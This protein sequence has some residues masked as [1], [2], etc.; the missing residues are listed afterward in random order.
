MKKKILINEETVKTMESLS[1][2]WKQINRTLDA[3]RW[4]IDLSLAGVFDKDRDARS[5]LSDVLHAQRN[6]RSAQTPWKQPNEVTVK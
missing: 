1:R 5:I 4:Q 2:E 3:I 6:K